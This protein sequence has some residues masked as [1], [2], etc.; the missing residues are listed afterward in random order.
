MRHDRADSVD[1][2]SRCVHRTLQKTQ[3]NRRCDRQCTCQ[4]PSPCVV[5]SPNEVVPSCSEHVSPA[6]PSQC[7]YQ[8]LITG[9]FCVKLHNTACRGCGAWPHHATRTP[10]AC[11]H[12]S[13]A[14]RRPKAYKCTD[15][16]SCMRTPSC[17]SPRAVHAFM[18][19]GVVTLLSPYTRVMRLCNATQTALLQI[20]SQC[21][22]PP[23]HPA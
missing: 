7:L 15:S 16:A 23:E 4:H 22:V 5:L 6:T 19:W 14:Y 10:Y 21:D 11:S 18:T 17:R 13:T 12:G 1:T 8:K 3:R 20:T 9:M 2:C